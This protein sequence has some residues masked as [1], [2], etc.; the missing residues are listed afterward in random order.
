LAPTALAHV[1]TAAALNLYL[2]DAWWTGTPLSTTHVSHYEQLAL[3][4]PA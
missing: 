4:L 1:L 3:T 2:L